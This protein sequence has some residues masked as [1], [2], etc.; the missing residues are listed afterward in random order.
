MN[1]AILR[2]ATLRFVPTALEKAMDLKDLAIGVNFVANCF[3]L[4]VQM[5]MEN[6]GM[7][8]HVMNSEESLVMDALDAYNMTLP[9]MMWKSRIPL[10]PS[11]IPII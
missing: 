10:H 1:I 2:T 11:W 3:A 4:F 5:L 8:G 6:L 7:F 9:I